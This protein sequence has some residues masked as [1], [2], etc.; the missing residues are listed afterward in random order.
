MKR[1]R[2]RRDTLVGGLWRNR[3]CNTFTTITVVLAILLIHK[4]HQRRCNSHTNKDLSRRHNFHSRDR[5]TGVG[6]PT[7]PGEI[8][9]GTLGNMRKKRHMSEDLYLE[10]GKHAQ[11]AAEQGAVDVLSRSFSLHQR[12]DPRHCLGLYFWQRLNTSSKPASRVSKKGKR[13]QIIR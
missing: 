10:C 9:H 4:S 13:P 3:P 7:P 12:Q 2:H 1:R 11:E 5:A 8:A 6:T